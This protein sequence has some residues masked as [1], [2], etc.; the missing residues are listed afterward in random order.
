VWATLNGL[1]PERLPEAAEAVLRGV[2]WRRRL[3]REPVERWLTTLADSP[4]PEP[5]SARGAN[6]ALAHRERHR[7]SIGAAVGRLG[8]E[9]EKKTRRRAGPS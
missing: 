3:G 4:R 7:A 2:R 5:N 8:R 1:F 6:A 9:K